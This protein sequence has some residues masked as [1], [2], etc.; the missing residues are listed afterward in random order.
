MT[1]TP[2][3]GES[4]TFDL[5]QGGPSYRVA[6]RLGLAGP[7]ARRRLL[8]IALLLLVAW[9]PLALLSLAAGRALGDKVAV[10][11]VRDIEVQ[12]R[13]LV[14]LPLL[15]LAGMVVPISLAVQ[16]RHLR[17]MGIVP[18]EEMERL[19]SAQ[20][21]AVALRRSPIAEWLILV[22][23]YTLSLVLRI[24]IGFSEG[25]SSW[26]R[27]GGAITLA[28]WWHML[29]SLPILYFFLLRWI[30]IFMIWGRFL[31]KVSRLDLALTSTHPDRAGGLGFLGW[32]MSCF[33]SVLTAISTVIAAG[34]ADE[35]LHRGAS[36]D[37]L[38]YHLAIYVAFVV[39]V[40]HAPL[41]AF[42]GRLARCRFKGL[43]EFG[44]LVWRHDR[45]FDEKWL[46]PSAV[47]PAGNI[48]GSEDVQS[49][50]AIS[51][52]Y[53]HIDRMRMIPLDVK[54][55]VV[56][57]LAAAIP[58]VPLLGTAIPLRE[59]LMKLGEMVI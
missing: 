15:E 28:G 53:E 43:L 12:V 17:E 19:E 34:F 10:T 57:V 40:I 26:E 8:K 5:V 27:A 4:E 22:L 16:V 1:T 45:A 59:I 6:E 25:D 48:L 55:F 2:E 31:F 37:S 18:R 47:V 50:A 13:L 33:G 56:L 42:S 44:A 38:K 51:A 54:A 39:I 49:L 23:S 3:E 21:E 30:W 41:F 29:V 11:F 24:I 46:A 32:G 14:V 20:V 7:P 58:M 36:L 9:V 35:I 52:C